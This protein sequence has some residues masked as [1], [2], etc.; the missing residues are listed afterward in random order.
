MSMFSK[1]PWSS[2]GEQQ[3][4]HE[5]EQSLTSVLPTPQ[6]R[7]DLTLLVANCTETMRKGITDTF[8]LNQIG[9]MEDMMSKLK[10]DESAQNSDPAATPEKTEE[11]KK[12]AE[13]KA[14]REQAERERELSGPKMQELQKA[15]LQHFDDWRDSVLLR[16]GEVVNQREEAVSQK[17]EAHA[18]T[19]RVPSMKAPEPSKYDEGVSKALKELCPPTET[20]LVEL[21]EEH[22]ALILHSVLL[23]LLSLEHYSAHSRVLLL[24]LTSSLNLSI[25]FLADDESKIARGLLSAA[26]M[27]ADDET[28][29]KQEDNKESR[30]WKVGLASVA[31]A[32]LIGVTG[33]LAAPLVAAGIGSVMGGLGLGATAAAGYLGTLA[34]SSIIVGG[35]FGAYG[36]RM[37][38]QMMDQYAKEVEDFSFVPVRT[39]H[40]PRKIEKEYRRLRV[41]IGIS[42]W[43]TEKDE[44]VEPWKVIGPEMEA[45]ALRFELQALLNLGN[46]LTTMIRSAAWGYAKS[47]IIKRT[48]FA[49]L[50]AALWP[51]GLLK[52]S[53]IIDNPFSVAKSRADKAGEVLADALINRAQ[54]ERPVTLIGYSLGAR[55]IFTCLKSL[56]A[57]KA[58][59]LVENVVLLGAPTPSTAADWRLIRAVTTGRVVNVYS[60]S[61]YILGFLY[62]S[63]SIQYGVAGLEPVAY[64]PGVQNVDVT[65]LIAG[66]HTSYRYLCGRILRKIGFEDVD[67]AA[68]EQEEKALEKATEAE[69]EERKQNEASTKEGA[70]TE[71]EV[72]EMEGE[73]QKKNEASMMDWATEKFRAGGASASSAAIQAKEWVQRNANPRSGGQNASND[74]G[75]AAGA[76]GSSLI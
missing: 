16:I 7:S 36:G 14:Q 47:E 28:K 8:D 9:K 24:H 22:R 29:K 66:N 53:R 43:L 10:V 61:D 3:Q 41:A 51:L 2:G 32:A 20:P 6:A 54:G 68:V 49:S 74:V 58:F 59:G 23:L 70:T 63:S 25:G 34:S 31:G 65:D 60:T 56:A 64:V 11:E 38:G 50:T 35:L 27:K 52:V 4:Q 5:E 19:P 71:A 48:V 57:R 26:E 39:Y 46:S 21:E 72:K 76:V 30:K 33:G 45:F 13:E 17:K 62:R 37:T 73:V 42:G 40:K 12:R 69:E 15:A 18:Q 55:V 75:G 1:L 67:L 44:V